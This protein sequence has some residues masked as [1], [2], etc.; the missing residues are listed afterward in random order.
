MIQQH[1]PLHQSG[2]HVALEIKRGI[3]TCFFYN[4]TMGKIVDGLKKINLAIVHYISIKSSTF[5][6]SDQNESAFL[7]LQL[8]FF[9][10]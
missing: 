6:W 10:F 4:K 9:L 1:A 5:Q 8:W 2:F 7:L 3:F